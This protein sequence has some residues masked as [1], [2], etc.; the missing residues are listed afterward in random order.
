M[1][2]LGKYRHFKGGRYELIALAKHS[3]TCEDMVVYRALY[4]DGGIW[5]RPLSMWEE[6]VE[7]NGEEIISK[8][9]PRLA[10][11]EMENVVITPEMLKKMN[12]NSEIIFHG[13]AEPYLAE[14]EDG[15]AFQLMRV[16]Y[17]KKCTD[18]NGKLVLSEIVSLK[19]NFNK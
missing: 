17:Y 4:G 9:R 1:I 12:E 14:C 8:K 5:V 10:P 11:G 2:K 6:T 19:D 3:E 18:E 13:K 15:K 16:G 7:Y